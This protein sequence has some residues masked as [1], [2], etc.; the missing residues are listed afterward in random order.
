M[1][2]TPVKVW[3]TLGCAGSL[4]SNTT[5]SSNTA[6][7]AGA[8]Y[9]NTTGSYN[10][11]SGSSALYGNTTGSDNAAADVGTDNFESTC[12]GVVRRNAAVH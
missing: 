6:S 3:S 1:L 7:S 9:L 11:A 12:R 10:T 8:L 5:G 4:K 2:V